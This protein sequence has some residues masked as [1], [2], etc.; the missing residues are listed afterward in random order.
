MVKFDQSNLSVLS[1]LEKDIKLRNTLESI[2][3]SLKLF[4]HGKKTAAEAGISAL[5]KIVIY[6]KSANSCFLADEFYYVIDQEGKIKHMSLYNQRRFAKLVYSSDS[7]IAGL[8][9]LQMLL[10][11][12]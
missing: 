8:D 10:H 3:P 1:K 7:I 9:L 4:F 6:N 11:E 2:T 5:L 12:T